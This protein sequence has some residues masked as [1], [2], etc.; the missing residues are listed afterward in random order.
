MSDRNCLTVFTDEDRADRYQKGVGVGDI[1]QIISPG[2]LHQV[3]VQIISRTDIDHVAIDPSTT[4][5]Q[6]IPVMTL[7]EF[8]AALERMQNPGKET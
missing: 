2:T 6:R 3:I 4:T 1:V 7:A 8:T 5:K